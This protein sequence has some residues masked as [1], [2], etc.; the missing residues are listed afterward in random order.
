[1]FCVAGSCCCF[2]VTGG[3][4]VVEEDGFGRVVLRRSM[5]FCR[6]CELNVKLLWR[7]FEL[8]KVLGK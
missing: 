6:L 3:F 2:C 8:I 7:A 5:Y 1:M 4:L